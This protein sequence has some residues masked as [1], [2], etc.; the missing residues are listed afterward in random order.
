M[1]TALLILPTATYKASDFIEA[2]EQLDV[3][4]V[5]ASEEP[6]TLSEEFVL[7]DPSRPEW[8][9]AQL[10][11]YA[12][13]RGVDAIIP[14]DDGGVLMASLAASK[15]GLIHSAPH[16]VATTRNKAMLRRALAGR[17][18]PQPSFAIIQ[19]AD[20][21]EARCAEVG[22]PCVMKPLS[23]SG[24]RGVI[25]V[26]EARQATD[27]AERIRRI[28]ASAGENPNSPLLVEQYVSGDEIAWEGVL[29]EGKLEE[30]AVFD[31]PDPAEGPYFEETIYTTPSRHHP[32]MLL[33]AR[34][35]VAKAADAVGLTEGPVHAELR[36]DG[37]RLWF[38]EMAARSIGGL[39][40]RALRFGL[41]PTSLEFVLLRH[42]L[43][44]P[45]QTKRES[46]ASGVMMLPIPSAGVL[47]EV[48]G[49]EEALA[50]EG[51]TQLEITI[52]LGHR[53]VPLPEGDRY[54]GF[55]FAKGPGPADVERA[56]RV[57][58]S[59]LEL[60]IGS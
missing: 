34:D 9:A 32:E 42:A 43:G 45:V 44:L 10:E 39:C 52:P 58:Y 8:S 50:V 2:A 13:E 16:A 28:L 1:P 7:I 40:G 18:V 25:R 59:K 4:I 36:I 15:L 11:Q 37:G 22:F 21:V 24:S 12:V 30:L 35:I 19:G 27:T 49:E 23:L 41:I 20:D 46:V 26:D 48:R 56:L 51:V 6:P 60:V 54:L 57:G 5:L 33:E 53:V 14:V 17:G 38:L 47:S 55:L 31:K 3:D 29:R